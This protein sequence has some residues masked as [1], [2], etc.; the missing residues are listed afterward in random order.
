MWIITPLS[1]NFTM[2]P[3][4]DVPS[5]KVSV[6]VSAAKTLAVRPSHRLKRNEKFAHVGFLADPA[7][8]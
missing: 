3:V 6:S 5:V 8:R 2:S 4:T 7:R 1:S